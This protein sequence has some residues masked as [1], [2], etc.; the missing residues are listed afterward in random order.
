MSQNPSPQLPTNW[1]YTALITSA[2]VVAVF[3][4]FSLVQYQV[5]ASGLW[6]PN[7]HHGY[8]GDMFGLVNALASALAFALFLVT[9]RMQAAELKEQ[10]EQFRKMAAAQ[11]ASDEKM[12]LQT[13]LNALA[14]E[15]AN[16]V[17]L[18]KGPEFGRYSSQLNSMAVKLCFGRRA[19]WVRQCVEADLAGRNRP[20]LIDFGLAAEAEANLKYWRILVA[21]IDQIDSGNP[22]DASAI[23]FCQK[24]A[25]FFASAHWRR[26]PDSALKHAFNPL[27]EVVDQLRAFDATAPQ[28]A[29][30][31][32]K[33]T[34]A[35]AP[36]RPKFAAIVKTLCFPLV[37][38]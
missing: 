32:A 16:D 38:C 31:Q 28:A 5:I 11:S 21:Y 8:S 1:T 22:S 23:E 7:E 6:S 25:P 30:A 34:Q 14:L 36:P 17:E 33:L 37:V 20:T 10:R 2:G 15:A 24:I 27:I 12:Q 18:D 9:L 4:F 29:Q 3:L 26:L 13:Y 19:A 35:L